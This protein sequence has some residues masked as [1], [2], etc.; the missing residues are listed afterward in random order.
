MAARARAAV[1]EAYRKALIE[2]AD[3]PSALARALAASRSVFP[4]IDEHILQRVVAA[5]VRY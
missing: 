4:N 5:I 2:G 3:K 1:I